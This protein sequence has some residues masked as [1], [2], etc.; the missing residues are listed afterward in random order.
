[1]GVLLTQIAKDDPAEL[2]DFATRYQRSPQEV[3]AFVQSR[4]R[5]LLGEPQRWATPTRTLEGGYGDCGNSSRA[6]IALARQ[7]GFSARLRVFTKLWQLEPGPIGRLFCAPA[8]VCAQILDPVTRRWE[9]CECTLPASYG[10]HPLACARRLGIM[11][12][13]KETPPNTL[14][15]TAPDTTP[16]TPSSKLGALNYPATPEQVP[17]TKTPVTIQDMFDAMS[18]AWMAEFGTEPSRESILVLLAQ[19][20]IETA[21]GASMIQYNVGNFKHA[22]GDGWNW[23]T[24]GTTECDSQGNN[25]AG[26]QASFAAYPDLE[27]GVQVYISSLKSR[28]PL[29]WPAVLAGDP[30]AFADALRRPQA[31]H[32]GYYTAPVAQYESAMKS[33]YAQFAAMDLGNPS[34]S[35]TALPMAILLLGFAAAGVTYA[36]VQGYLPAGWWEPLAHPVR[37][38]SRL[39]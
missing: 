2:G 19:W 38:L 37:Y 29:A 31:G 18:E 12:D 32:G 1:L 26:Q 3:H 5:F 17:A 39:V 28:W 11:T 14:I 13:L 25:C 4:V 27:T 7:A 16:E 35:T 33:R 21:N 24:F 23:S 36:T 15:P 20:G 10:E 9:W 8:H 30:V 34:L 6:L 22:S